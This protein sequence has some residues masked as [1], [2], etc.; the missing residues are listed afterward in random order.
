MRVNRHVTNS[1]FDTEVDHTLVVPVDPERLGQVGSSL[2]FYS[3]G[4][5]FKPQTGDQ[6]PQLTSFVVFFFRF[7]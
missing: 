6:L 4:L 7:L 5:G 1:P 2:T 3:G